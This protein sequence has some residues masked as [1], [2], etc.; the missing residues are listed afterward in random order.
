[1]LPKDKM[2]LVAE[3]LGQLNDSGKVKARKQHSMG[4]A[5][6]S[7]LCRGCSIWFIH[8]HSDDLCLTLEYT[9]N[10]EVKNFDICR[11]A[12]KQ[13]K[14]LFPDAQNF[15]RKTNGKEGMCLKVTD[16]NID[17]LFKIVDDVQRTI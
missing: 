3:K 9:E 16:K 1:M 8:E 10:A 6:V 7:E 5:V 14:K 12:K 4:H 2:K 15:T 13:F 11:N 17:E